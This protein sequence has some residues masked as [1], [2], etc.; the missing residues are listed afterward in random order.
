MLLKGS[1]ASPGAST[2]LD[3][4]IG[5]FLRLTNHNASAERPWVKTE[6]PQKKH[7]QCQQKLLPI[8][9]HGQDIQ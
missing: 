3:K 7:G 6:I 9:F 1:T 4:G 5:M 2:Q 8:M